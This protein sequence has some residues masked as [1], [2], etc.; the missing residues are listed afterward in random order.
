[1]HVVANSYTFYGTNLIFP[2]AWHHFGI[3]A[4]HFDASIEAGSVVSISYDSAKAIAG[5][6]RAV[7]EALL[8]WVAIVRPA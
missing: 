7:V 6:H 4:R 1:M 3:C 8:A 5:T 2:L